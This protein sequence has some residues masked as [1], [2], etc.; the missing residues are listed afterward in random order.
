MAR[1]LPPSKRPEKR[2]Y[3]Y[4]RGP[5]SVQL[6]TLAVAQLVA[7]TLDFTGKLSGGP[8]LVN[9]FFRR[10]PK[11]EARYQEMAA[12]GIYPT[13]GHA[14][15][16]PKTQPVV[17]VALPRVAGDGLPAAPEIPVLLIGDSDSIPCYTVNELI[18]FIAENDPAVA[19]R[20]LGQE[21]LNALQAS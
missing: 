12:T 21:A 4:L 13:S 19:H 20:P 7:T 11:A 15:S 8:F 3:K 10:Y 6:N 18:E 9:V 16:N 17:F 1:K 14:Q 5:D 2:R